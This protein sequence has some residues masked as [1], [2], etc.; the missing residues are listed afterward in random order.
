MDAETYKSAAEVRELIAA[1]PD[2]DFRRMAANVD[3][4]IRNSFKAGVFVYQPNAG[5][6][7]CRIV[8]A[9]SVEPD[10]GSTATC[11][12]KEQPEWDSETFTIEYKGEYHSI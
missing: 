2:Q 11:K 3:V 10:A 6:L 9:D 4:F 5:L 1:D 12:A 7:P 8:A